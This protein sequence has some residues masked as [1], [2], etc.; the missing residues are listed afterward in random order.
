[1]GQQ[2]TDDVEFSLR[3]SH[4]LMT[5]DQATTCGKCGSTAL[6]VQLYGEPS[7][8][9]EYGPNVRFPGCNVPEDA[10]DLACLSCGQRRYLVPEDKSEWRAAAVTNTQPAQ[11]IWRYAARAREAMRSSE[12]PVVSYAGLWLLLASVAPM[13]GNDERSSELLEFDSGE[14]FYHAWQ[15]VGSHHRT[16]AAAFGGWIADEV[17]LKTPL[18]IALKSLPS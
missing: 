7:V 5:M 12:T 6:R 8:W 14:A 11:A 4:S 15:L 9:Y 13:I 1:M 2:Q 3:H 16:A 18:P 17:Q 10:W